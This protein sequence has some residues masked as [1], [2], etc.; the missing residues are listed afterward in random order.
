MVFRKFST[1]LFLAFILAVPAF[2]QGTEGSISGTVRDATGA[3][4]P[5]VEVTVTRLETG[6]MRTVI[7]DDA[8]RYVASA[9]SIGSYEISAQLAGFKRFVETAIELNVADRLRIDVTLEVGEVT[10]VV[11]VES[12]AIQIQ[13]ETSELSDVIEGE[14]ITELAIN[15]RNFV[16]L[17]A[18]TTGVSNQLPDV[19]GVGVTG[20]TQGLFINGQKGHFV[21]WMVDGAQNTDVGNQHSLTTYPA[22][23]ALSEFR[24]LTS[25]YSAEYGTAGTGIVAAATKSGGQEYH[26]S[27]YE[28][29][30]NDVLDAADFFAS[31]G[32]GGE[33]TKSPLILNNYGYTI[34][35]P[36]IKGKEKDFFFWSQEWKT[37]RRGTVIR[38]ATPTQA[39]R[40]GDFSALDPITDPLTG[41]S[42]AGN[43]IPDSRINPESRKMLDIYPLPNVATGEFL[44][45]N[46]APSV[47]QNFR[48]EL[49][50]WDHH[51]S[52]NVT[53]VGRFI[54]DSFDDTPPTT[55]W[56]NQ[57]FPNINATINTP[58]LNF[59]L[60]LT[61]VMNPRLVHEFNYS[62][63]GNNIDIVMNGQFE[64]PSNLNIPQLFPENRADR[65]PNIILSQGWGNLNTGSW[66]W[67]NL[68]DVWTWDDKWTWTRGDHSLKFGAVYMW[69]RKNQD[70]F[71]PTQG[72]FN[73]TGKFTGNAVADFM[74]GLA[75]TYEE[76]D[77]QREGLYRYWQFETFLQDDW[78]VKPNLTL[79]LGLRYFL[80]PHLYEKNNEV[81][82][83]VTSQYDPSQAVQLDPAS[84]A[85]IE[86]S[87]NLLNGVVQ[88]GQTG[89]PRYLTETAKFDFAPRLGFAWDL[90]GTSSIV[91]RGGWGFGYYR[92]EGNDTYNFINNPPFARRVNVNEPL[93][94]NLAVGGVS[95]SFPPGLSRFEDTFDPPQIQQWSFGLQFDTAEFVRDSLFEISYVGTHVEGLPLSRNINQPLPV[96]SFDFDPA[97]NE[98]TLSTD[99]FRPFIGY[100][101]IDE[102]AT[103][104]RSNYH[105]L[106]VNF[107]KRFSRG[108]RFQLAYTFGKSLNNSES[109]EDNP[110][111]AFDIEAEYSLADWDV[112]HAASINY[113]WELPFFKDQ[114]GFAGKI[115]GGWELSGITL[116]QSGRPWEVGM[117]LPNTGLAN[118]PNLNG[119]VEG[120]ETIQQ[121]F[122]TTVF[123]QPAP[124][125]FGSAGRNIIRGPGINKWDVSLFKNNRLPWFGGESANLQFRA[126]FFNLP[127]HPIFN[128]LALNLGSGN[129][130]QLT[131]TR[132]P[133]IIQFGLKLDF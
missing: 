24:I 123:S 99:L 114:Q 81:T 1:A 96:Q 59:M 64:R 110:Q 8:G 32:P 93:I 128:S 40:A 78:K 132:D 21:N 100:G 54:Y 14:Q 57:S 116:L 104:G 26:G 133:R 125:F 86:G 41:E 33:K 115:L 120:P 27:V 131:G 72:Q 83:F 82:A 7:S 3:V 4:I 92:T 95:P 53:L 73:F 108:F 91:L 121:W 55:L 130:S 107:N 118:R 77:V 34:G 87:G 51:F 12:G 20:G 30:R 98:G 97:I 44:N 60:K 42:F 119:S 79:N 71:G 124:G 101:G 111:N 25:N 106:Q 10:E 17:A 122:S 126:E 31:I 127:N 63:A 45:F 102:R 84:G 56:T 9:L 35:G 109:F 39:M 5:G 43:I 74:L 48:Q 28:F 18:L 67:N 66:P 69:Q 117:S 70:A 89:L 85:I 13:T 29:H 19:V 62:Q 103:A 94:D 36:V 49:V 80:I 88:A 129:F 50:R 37:T 52:D 23:E 90:T 75:N 65:I 113:I 76:L 47:P 105:S 58:G 16:S 112:T 46:L 6:T 11:T 15:G 38:A 2:G 68:N 61:H 22:V